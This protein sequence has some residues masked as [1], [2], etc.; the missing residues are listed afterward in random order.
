MSTHNI[1]FHD[2]TRKFLTLS[3]IFVFFLSCQTNLVET[4]KRIRIGH[5][6]TSHRRSIYIRS[7][8]YVL[9]I[10]LHII[11]LMQ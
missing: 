7:N 10:A 9:C 1:Q 11:P 2:K 4:R 8:V 5:G 3:L 6:E